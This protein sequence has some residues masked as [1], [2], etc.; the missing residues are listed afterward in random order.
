MCGSS[1]RSRRSPRRS[2]GW[3]PAPSP[4]QA[5]DRPKARSLSRADLLET[6]SNTATSYPLLSRQYRFQY[7][8]LFLQNPSADGRKKDSPIHLPRR[9]FTV[10]LSM[11]FCLNSCQQPDCCK[12]FF[13][14]LAVRPVLR[15]LA[16][17]R[18][19][20]SSIIRALTRPSKKPFI[21]LYT[22]LKVIYGFVCSDHFLITGIIIH[23]SPP[24]CKSHSL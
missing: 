18:L 3:S 21:I 17:T 14:Y 12:Y 13:T 11:S 1:P 10:C 15:A 16:E 6:V 5:P 4:A 24:S 2:A 7:S 8:T 20:F 9:A 23:D 19:P 22:L